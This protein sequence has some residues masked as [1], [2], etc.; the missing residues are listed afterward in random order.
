MKTAVDCSN[1]Y[2]FQIIDK[3][4]TLCR[5]QDTPI[6]TFKHLVI[7]YCFKWIEF[8]TACVGEDKLCRFEHSH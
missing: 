4:T 3:L 6:R 2:T 8:P 7:V 5:T 1:N